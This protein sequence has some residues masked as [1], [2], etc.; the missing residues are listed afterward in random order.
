VIVLGLDI[1]QKPGFAILQDGKPIRYG[2]LFPDRSRKDYGPYPYN[3][4]YF[5]AYTAERLFLEVIEPA[6][7]Q[8]PTILIVIEETSKGA[9][10]DNYDQKIL[11][12]IHYCV[13]RRLMDLKV[14]VRYVRDGVWKS[15]AGARQ[16]EKERT[17]NKLI[18]DQKAKTGNK[19]AKL[20][21]GDGRGPRVVGKKGQKNYSIRAVKERFGIELKR[22]DEDT[23][24]ALLLAYAATQDETPFCDGTR[25]GGT[26]KSRKIKKAIGSRNKKSPA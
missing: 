21:L 7:K 23:A 12:F 26:L 10:T 4:V 8:F 5:A 11:E 14:Q 24:E 15:V 22:Q 20:D 19:L 25:Y 9:N 2:T 17:L 13:V 3:F 1:S 16:N 18:A 6:V